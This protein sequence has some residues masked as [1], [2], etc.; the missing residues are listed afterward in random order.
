M[1]YQ[2]YVAKI[3]EVRAQSILNRS[4]IFDYCLNPYTGC[5]H[6][7]RYCYAGLFMRRYSG[8]AEP[9]GQFVDIKINAPELLRRQLPR[10]RRGTVWI[11]S[12]CDPYQPVESRYQ[13]TRKCLAELSRYDFPVFIQTKSD[14]VVRDLD[15]LK[16]LPQLEVGFSLAT[17]DDR[18]A[19]LFEPGA[20]SITRRLKALEKIKSLNLKTFAFVGPI[21]PLNPGRLVRQLRGLVDRVFIDRLNY[22]SQFIDFYHRH[23]LLNYTGDD[24]FERMKKILVAELEK[25]KLPYELIF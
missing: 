10:A 6:G 1:C 11:A 16:D 9:W 21:L 18:V 23:N 17:D 22:V 24:F 12:V 20:P 19:A 4:K 25:A 7:C 13:L 2:I 14:L 5:T 15:L 8:H 3:S